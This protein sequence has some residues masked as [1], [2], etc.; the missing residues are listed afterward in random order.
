MLRWMISFRHFSVVIL[1][2]M[3][4]MARAQPK[5]ASPPRTGSISGHVL[6]DNKAAANVEVAAYDF[7]GGN[8]R[9]PT[10]Q[11]RTDSEGYYHLTGLTAANYQVTSFT[12][13]MV[14]AENG[15]QSAYNLPYFAVSKNVLLTAGED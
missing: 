8:R 1:L 9:I 6:I 3:L 5:D 13:S 12:P 2:C 10:A 14:A 11:A 4:T 15:T 7:E